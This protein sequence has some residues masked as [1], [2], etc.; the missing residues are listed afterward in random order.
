MIKILDPDTLSG[1]E[2]NFIKQT[3]KTK[4]IM[5]TFSITEEFHNELNEYLKSNPSEGCSRSGFIVRIVTS[6]MRGVIK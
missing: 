3:G 2:K 1:R 5:K 4:R 6:Y